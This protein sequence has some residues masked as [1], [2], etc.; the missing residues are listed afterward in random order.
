MAGEPRS[1][2]DAGL[3]L[4]GGLS[5]GNVRRRVRRLCVQVGS[6]GYAIPTPVYDSRSLVLNLSTIWRKSSVALMR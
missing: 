1:E 5:L 4:Q 3:R 2:R 6:G